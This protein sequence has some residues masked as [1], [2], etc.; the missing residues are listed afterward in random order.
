MFIWVVGGVVKNK[1]PD[2]EK[3]ACQ[4]MVE[5][6]GPTSIASPPEATVIGRL[7]NVKEWVAVVSLVKRIERG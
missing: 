2:P 4:A 5:I 1:E 7:V 6:A 3:P